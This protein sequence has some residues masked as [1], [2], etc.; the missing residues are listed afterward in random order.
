[1]SLFVLFLVVF[2][3]SLLGSLPPGMICL[4][5]TLNTLKGG[6]R[7]GLWV[8]FGAVLVEWIQA[9][10]SVRFAFLFTV[11]PAYETALLWISM[12]VFTVLAVYHLF[13]SSPDEQHNNKGEDFNNFFL[14]G[15]FISS[16]NVMVFPYWIFYSTYLGTQGWMSAEWIDTI[17]FCTAVSIGSFIAF[18]A[19]CLLASKVLSKIENFRRIANKVVGLLFLGFAI[20][21]AYQ[22]F[23]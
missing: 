16:A 21:Q 14:K 22:L 3:L 1:M 9:F 15:V 17:V 10:I 7:C 5:A 4:T 6:L 11:N 13:L 23:F 12:L 2:G 18:W 19:Y 8:A 20:F